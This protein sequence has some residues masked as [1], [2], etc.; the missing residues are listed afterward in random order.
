MSN[1]NKNNNGISEKNLNK[2]LE[3]LK[4]VKYGSVTLVIQ[5]GVVVQIERNEKM[6]IV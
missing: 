1:N 4:V 6:R 2:L 3:I 5:D